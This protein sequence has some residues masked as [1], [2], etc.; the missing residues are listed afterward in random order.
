MFFWSKAYVGAACTFAAHGLFPVCKCT[1]H[2]QVRVVSKVIIP[3]FINMRQPELSNR[4]WI[5]STL[6]EHVSL[7]ASG[8]WVTTKQ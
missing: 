2:L 7:L 4:L 8:P 3:Y 1:L 5:M 6:Q